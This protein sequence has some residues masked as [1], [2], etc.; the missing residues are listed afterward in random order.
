MKRSPCTTWIIKHFFIFLWNRFKELISTFKHNGF[1]FKLQ[2]HISLQKLIKHKKS[3][4][5]QTIQFKICKKLGVSC[6]RQWSKRQWRSR[7]WWTAALSHCRDLRRKTC[8]RNLW[9][10]SW[11]RCRSLSFCDDFF[12]SR[13]PL[14]RFRLEE[15]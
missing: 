14:F 9:I 13:D 3:Q 1:N 4:S 10:L 12:G 15:S 2:Q 7:T 8:N 6:T 5:T 11:N